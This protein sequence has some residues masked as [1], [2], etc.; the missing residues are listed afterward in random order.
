MI[1]QELLEKLLKKE[2]GP[3]VLVEDCW[4]L[5]VG[6]FGRGILKNH[7]SIQSRLFGLNGDEKK[8]GKKGAFVLKNERIGKLIMT[9]KVN[10]TANPIEI[11]L[12]F[13]DNP[14]KIEASSYQS[15]RI[16]EVGSHWGTRWY[17]KCRGCSCGKMVLYLPSGQPEFLCAKCHNLAYELCRINKRVLGGLKYYLAKQAKIIEKQE[18]LRHYYYNGNR[19]KRA[20]RFTR[21]LKEFQ[22]LGEKLDMVKNPAG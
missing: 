14:Q 4:K 15:I 9:Y 10:L 5:S 1:N 22:L 2:K 3:K 20:E 21:Q 16:K 8:E 19:T 17:F 7:G 12:N 18:K 6:D 11:E 13:L